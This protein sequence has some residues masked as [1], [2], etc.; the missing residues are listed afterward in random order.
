[1]NANSSATSKASKGIFLLGMVFQVSYEL[2]SSVD[3][4]ESASLV[5]SL[6]LIRHRPGASLSLDLG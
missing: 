6:H 2:F 3:Q 4:P 5:A 1:M